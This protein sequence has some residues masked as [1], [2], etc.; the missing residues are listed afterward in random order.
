MYN[1]EILSLDIYFVLEVGLP[2]F[3][4]LTLDITLLS[5]GIT[6]VYHYVCWLSFLCR[7]ITCVFP[8]YV[9][10]SLF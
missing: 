2:V 7:K 9:L 4:R 5:A 6:G 1:I 3:P 8:Q 10:S